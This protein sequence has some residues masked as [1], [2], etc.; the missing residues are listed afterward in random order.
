MR[1]RAGENTKEEKFS[2]WEGLFRGLGRMGEC[3]GR[4]R[5]AHARRAGEHRGG[6][7]TAARAAA[8]RQGRAHHRRGHRRTTDR[9][10]ARVAARLSAAMYLCRG[11]GRV[12]APLFAARRRARGRRGRAAQRARGALFFVRCAAGF[13]CSSPC[14]RRQRSCSPPPRPAPWAGYPLAEPDLILVDGEILQN[15]EEARAEAALAA[16]CA[17]ELES[18]ARFTEK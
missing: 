18:D 3:D 13:R 1:G 5:A 17:A 12:H 6:G 14:A 8:L 15:A 2:V 11:G 10:R 4:L 9:A 7:R 16:L